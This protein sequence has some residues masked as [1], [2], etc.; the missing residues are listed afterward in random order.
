MK[1]TTYTCSMHPEVRK[2]K[3]GMCPECGMQLLP[4]SKEVM[5]AGATGREKDYDKH[6]GHNT[7]TFLMKF[8][9]SFFLTVPVVLYSELPRRFLGWTAPAFPGSEYLSPVLGTIVFFYGGWVFIRGAYREIRAGLPGMMTLIGI[10]I[11]T[12]YAFSIFQIVFG[13]EQ[14]LFWELTTLITVM[15]LG[16]WI[17]M[18]SVQGAQSALR[19][20]SKLLPDTAE[21]VLK[22]EKIKVIP[23]SELKVDNVFLVRPGG[24]IPADGV[25][26]E[27]ESEANE[28]MITGESVPVKKSK[29]D[30]IIAGTINGDGSLKVRVTKIGEDTF[31]S[32]VMRLVEEA[33]ASKSRIQVLSDRAAYYLTMVAIIG[34]LAS[35]WYWLLA[36]AG[37]AF[38]LERFVAVLVIACPHAL[39]LAIPLVASIS[40]MKAAEKGFLVR[41]RL[42]LEAARNIDIVLFDKTGTLTKGEYGVDTVIPNPEFPIFQ[43]PLSQFES[44]NSDLPSAA[45]QIL[46]YAA[47]VDSRSEHFTSKAIVQ[48]A[49]KL[50]LE[51][52]KVESFE[53]LPGKGVR[54][55]VKSITVLVGGE[56]LLKEYKLKIGSELKSKIKAFSDQGKTINFVIIGDQLAGALILGDV[57]REESKEAITA[58]KVMGVRTAMITG[59]SEE[60]AAWVADESGIDEYFSRV[61][62]EEKAKKV[63]DLQKKGLKVAMVGD[64]INDA[65]ALTQADLGVAIGAGTNVAV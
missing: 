63:V 30:E 26:V 36:G 33:Q 24:R 45:Y 56:K 25:V 18:K 37:A 60:V 23:L 44:S 48:E 58:L 59:D 52:F 61:L 4:S 54:G 20:L 41:Q 9:I 65:P 32:G 35:F 50:G 17:E 42:A 12:A 14:T 40:T 31:L 43:L 16:H 51:L 55:V 3:P 8:W 34:G 21:L 49:E 38:A 5:E 57:L 28:S 53:R 39:G 1:K 46:Q 6:A 47:S 22:N 10:A 2:E 29:S 27:G 13:R 11:S 64:G 62:P 7:R 19:V 15:L